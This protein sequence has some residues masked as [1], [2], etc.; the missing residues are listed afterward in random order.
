MSDRDL[1]EALLDENAEDGRR[2]VLAAPDGTLTPGERPGRLLLPGSFNPLH[3]GHVELA[4][5]AAEVAGLPESEVAFELSVVNV[6]KP[7]L[8]VFEVERRVQ[9]FHDA[10]PLVLT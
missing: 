1:L 10:W 8:T 4:L 2:F 9:Q 7:P 6:D 3:A 5:A